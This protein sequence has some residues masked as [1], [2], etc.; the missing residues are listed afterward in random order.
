MSVNDQDITNFI[1]GIIELGGIWNVQDDDNKYICAFDETEPTV[2]TVE[3]ET[4][5]LAVYGTMATDAWIINPF[6]EGVA[7]TQVDNWFYLTANQA[8]SAAV[9]ATIRHILTVGARSHGKKRDDQPGDTNCIPY[10]GSFTSKID[11]K[12]IKEFDSI[13]SDLSEFFNIYYNRS[14]RKCSIKMKIFSQGIEKQYPSVRENTWGILESITLK[15][16][17]AEKISEYDAVPD[18]VDVPV[19][20]A[21]TTI[22][23]AV[24][25]QLQEP[26]KA[27][28]LREIKGVEELKEHL[29]NLDAY[30]KRAKWCASAI[31]TVTATTQQPVVAL[32]DEDTVAR[33]MI[34]LSGVVVPQPV[35]PVQVPMSVPMP[36]PVA[37]NNTQQNEEYELAKMMIP[38]IGTP[39]VTPYNYQGYIC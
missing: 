34:P 19:L 18:S 31:N 27:M 32:S 37:Y 25:S 9:R 13:S 6:R 15:L 29:Q 38:S 8:L 1:A 22:L 39:S 28:E 17:K 11:N 12:T 5:K 7:A 16:L 24:Y 26:M 21:F 30:Y 36:T 2:Y 14:K 20:D 4:K 23:L 33:A 3:G 10:L 35:M